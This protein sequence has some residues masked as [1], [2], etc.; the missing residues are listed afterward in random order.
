M[1]RHMLRLL[2][3]A[4]SY[5]GWHTLSKHDPAARRAVNRLVGLGILEWN[6]PTHQFRLTQAKYEFSA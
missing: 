6:Q 3:F 2:K 1:G 4:I 5:P